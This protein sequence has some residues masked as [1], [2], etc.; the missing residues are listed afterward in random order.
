MEGHDVPEFRTRPDGTRYPITPKKGKTAGA[1][2]AAAVVAGLVAATNGA[3]AT[4][5]VGTALDTAV[6]QGA[7][8]QTTSG[9]DSASRGKETETWQRMA[10]REVKKVIKQQLRC[11]VQSYGQVQQFFVQT[12]CDSLNQAL[13]ALGD[14]RGD[15]MAVS[16]MWVTMSS[17][18]DADRLKRLEDT[19]GTGDVTPFGTEALELGGI[20]FTAQ[21]YASREDGSLLVVAETEPVR[22]QPS[23]TLLND[24]AK[25]A[26]VFPPLCGS[27]SITLPRPLPCLPAL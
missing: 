24:V 1:V 16:V 15:I 19:Y 22:G 6:Q 14:T 17:A 13:F 10:L 25:V 7:D 21:H 27:G 18:G 26:S 2:V 12:P 5:S 8:V 4:D 11:A 20:K 23:A 9:E 3:T